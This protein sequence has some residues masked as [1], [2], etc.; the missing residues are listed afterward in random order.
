MQKY[1]E[2]EVKTEQQLKSELNKIMIQLKS[3]HLCK[4]KILSQQEIDEIIKE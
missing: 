2:L 4:E 3:H 1:Y